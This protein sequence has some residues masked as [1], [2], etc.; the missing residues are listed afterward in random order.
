MVTLLS[1]LF[2]KNILIVDDDKS[3]VLLIET[4]LE[5]EGYTNIF[6]ANSAKDAYEILEKEHINLLL[7]DVLMPEIGGLE[8]CESIR[9]DN[10]YNR[11]PIIMV[12]ADERDNTLIDSFELGAD[13]YITKPIHKTNL[14]VRIRR[15]LDVA[16]KDALIL[17]QSRMMAVNETVQMLAHQWRQPL[18]LISAT[19][20]DLSLSH[21]F[22]QLSAERLDE[23]IFKINDAVNTLSSTLDEFSKVTKNQNKP[24]LLMMH[25]TIDKSLELIKDRFQANS[26]NLKV[27]Y[28]D[29]YK[30]RFFFNDFV[31]I[32][33]SIYTNSLEAFVRNG[34]DHDKK[35]TISTKQDDFSTIITI[36]DNAGGVEKDI[37]PNIFEPYVT[38]KDERNGAGLGLYHAFHTLSKHMKAGIKV[39]SKGSETTVVIEIPNS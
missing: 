14:I 1:D 21:E 17:N 18:A 31:K 28:N 39:V 5:E 32:L 24:S 6:T 29:I 30:I 16:Y 10:K 12:T 2:S 3:N 9:K 33:I 11:M 34:V 7:L 36:L 13:D 37:L 22:E 25:E 35:M 8:A 4:L 20:I 38:S 19:T 23:A 27:D 26:I 15:V